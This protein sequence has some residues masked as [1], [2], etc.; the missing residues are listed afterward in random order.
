MKS[1]SRRGFTLIELLTVIAIIGVMAAMLF[2]AINAVRKKS[3]IATSQST[4]SQWCTAVNR[5][6]SVYGFYP[7][8]GTTYSSAADSLHKLDDPATTRK[9]IKALSAK[10]PSGS[11][12]ISADRTVLNR[13]AEEFCAFSKED[14]AFYDSSIDTGNTLLVDKLGNYKIRVVF[15]NDSTGSIKKIAGVTI[16]DDIN[17]AKNGTGL[18]IDSATGGIP[19]RVIIFT[20][21]GEAASFDGTT[22]T[23]MTGD[24]AADIIAIQ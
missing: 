22:I 17:S 15:D 9:F 20:A 8:I 4:F 13:N 1:E 24:D 12:L 10:N 2:P 19:A 18:G 16:P 6:K 21:A 23:P 7:N 5:Y 11:A 3:K 14:Y